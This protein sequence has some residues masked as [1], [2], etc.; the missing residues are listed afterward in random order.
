MHRTN[1][2][3]ILLCFSEITDAV[4]QGYCQGGFSAAFTTVTTI[5][6]SMNRNVSGVIFHLFIVVIHRLYLLGWQ[7]GTGGA[8]QLLLARYVGAYQPTM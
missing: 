5:F 8:R 2:D 4:G 1:S 3:T 7:S 6:L